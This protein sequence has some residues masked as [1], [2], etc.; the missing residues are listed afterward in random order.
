MFHLFDF[1]IFSKIFERSFILDHSQLCISNG[2]EATAC[3]SE[4]SFAKM[5]IFHRDCE[6]EIRYVCTQS[7]TIPKRIKLEIPDCSQMKDLFQELSIGL[8]S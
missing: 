4:G 5:L 1:K 3:Q 8:E 7:N 2:L 6:T